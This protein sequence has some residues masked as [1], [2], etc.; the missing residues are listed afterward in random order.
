MRRCVKWLSDA[1]ELLCGF[2]LMVRLLAAPACNR[3]LRW[4]GRHRVRYAATIAERHDEFFPASRRVKTEI[5]N[6][7]TFEISRCNL[8]HSACP[9]NRAD[10]GREVFTL[11]F[12]EIH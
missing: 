10:A 7:R 9:A 6:A 1:C 4:C 8:A 11:L 12:A 2:A 5:S 3:S